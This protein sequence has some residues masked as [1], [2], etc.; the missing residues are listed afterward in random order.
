MTPEKEQLTQAWEVMDDIRVAM[1]TTWTNKGMR[2]RPLT[3]HVDTQAEQLYFIV[4]FDTDICHELLANDEL[5]LSFVDLKAQNYVSITT[6]AIVIQDASMAKKL[7]NIFARAWFPDGPDDPDIRIIQAK[8]KMLEYWEGESSRLVM[9][10]EVGKSLLTKKP[11][12]IGEKATV[13]Y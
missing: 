9:A 11:P 4:P 10:W 13:Q 3:A 5:H 2:S 7:W 8:P 6:S 12:A 1:A